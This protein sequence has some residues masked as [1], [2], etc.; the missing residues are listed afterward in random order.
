MT[1]VP[2]SG[3][4]KMKMYPT[5]FVLL[6]LSITRALILRE[7]IVYHKVSK[8]EVLISIVLELGP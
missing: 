8:A 1:E 3:K 2:E 6:M 4:S 7:N 5:V